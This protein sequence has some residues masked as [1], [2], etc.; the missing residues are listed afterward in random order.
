MSSL[1]RRKFVCAGVAALLLVAGGFYLARILTGPV[2]LTELTELPEGCPGPEFRFK[3]PDVYMRGLYSEGQELKAL[4]GWYRCHPLV[5]GDTVLYRYV[6]TADPV[7]KVVRA[8]PGDR[9]ALSP[10]RK[11]RGWNL[12]VNGDFILSADGYTPYFFGA[13]T[14]PT[15]SLY[16]KTRHGILRE[17]EA[18]VL[19]AFP[20]GDRDSGLFG[21]AAINDL[22]ARV[23][24]K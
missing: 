23:E 14:P 4:P 21:L 11:K 16:E 22:V 7:V 1:R 5:R 12:K 2:S 10:D 18:I 13:E 20:P 8:I 24:A 15:L 19:S 9:F 17:G 6:T 3:M